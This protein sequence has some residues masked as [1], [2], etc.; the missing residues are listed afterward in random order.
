LGWLLFSGPEIIGLSAQVTAMG[1][2]GLIMTPNTDWMEKRQLGLSFSFIPRTYK[3]SGFMNNYYDDEHIYAVRAGITDWMEIYLNVTRLPELSDRIGIGDRHMDFRFRL[4]KEEKYGFSA[5]LILSP[6]G[7]IN[8][9][10]NHDS[11]VLGKKIS[12]GNDGVLSLSGGYGF[13]Y[14]LKGA[15]LSGFDGLKFNFVSKEEN[16]MLYLNGFF[17][18]LSWSWKKL[19]GV[20]AEYDSRTINAGIFVKPKPWILLQ[21]HTFEGKDWGATVSLHFPL[22]ASPK[23]L[24]SHEK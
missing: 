16:N 2:P 23:E 1:K 24:R 20:Q 7:S 12:L 5:V 8:Q 18:G 3:I 13:P 22:D 11:L 4:L 15:F 17:G 10:L 21:G 14:I 9:Y 19:F 6:P